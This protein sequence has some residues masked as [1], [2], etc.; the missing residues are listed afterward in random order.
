M[1]GGHA[2]SAGIPAA[3]RTVQAAPDPSRACA[4]S[5]TA[6]APRTA[7]RRKAGARRA[8]GTRERTPAVPSRACRRARRAHRRQMIERPAQLARAVMRREEQAGLAMY[9]F[10]VRLELPQPEM[11]APVLPAENGRQRPAVAPVP[12]DAARA[13][14]RE[15]CRHESRRRSPSAA[16]ASLAA[17]KIEATIASPSCSAQSGCGRTS[18][19]SCAP[20]ASTRPRRSS[21]TARLACV[22][23]SIAR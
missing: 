12:A 5:R 16:S 14:A 1:T 22:P 8:A 11:R 20:L 2:P 4:D 6:C 19:I 23:W 9:F 18:A 17:V 21:T 7:G 10:A 3:S 13:L 15:T